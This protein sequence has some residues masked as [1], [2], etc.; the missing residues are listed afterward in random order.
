LDGE[1]VQHV[2]YVPFGEVFIEERNNTWN[3]P[4]LFNGK[5]L[6]EETGLYYYGARY[7]N[8]RESLWLSVDPLA[9]DY[10]NVSPYAYTFQNPVKFIDPTGM[11]G[12]DTGGDPPK[13]KRDIYESRPADGGR[14]LVKTKTVSSGSDQDDAFVNVMD[15]QGYNIATYTGANAVA[16]YTKDHGLYKEFDTVMSDGKNAVERTLL[17]IGDVTYIALTSTET[18]TIIFAPLDALLA[19]KVINSFRVVGASKG[20]FDVLRGLSSAVEGASPSRLS[21]VGRAIDKHRN[22]LRLVTSENVTTNVQKNKYGAEALRYLMENGTR[23][24]KTTAN[25]GKV[26]EYK[27]PSGLGARFSASDSRFIGFL[28]K[29]L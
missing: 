22:I 18:N 4:Y 21:P 11:E 12:E 14:K 26:V 3:T 2:E 5:E 23:T 27:L 24:T 13:G 19:G 20:G 6:D 17:A 8:P 9:E 10:P 1:I 15:S 29:G 7:Y 25:F 16:E 28:G